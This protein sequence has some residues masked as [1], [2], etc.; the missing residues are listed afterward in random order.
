MTVILLHSQ[1]NGISLHILAYPCI[2]L[3]IPAYPC[4]MPQPEKAPIPQPS[5][6]DDSFILQLG[7]EPVRF[8]AWLDRQ[9]VTTK[10]QWTKVLD[11]YFDDG[12]DAV[13]GDDAVADFISMG[14][15]RVTAVAAAH[16]ISD[17][18]GHYCPWEWA[19]IE[20]AEEINRLKYG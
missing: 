19:Q 6:A 3:H 5:D 20:V 14:F 8:K 13:Q 9:Q 10:I 2:S 15:T 11:S 16:R 17:M 1:N 12:N 4:N 18:Y 7:L